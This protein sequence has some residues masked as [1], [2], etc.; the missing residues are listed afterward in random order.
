MTAPSSMWAVCQRSESCKQCYV[1]SCFSNHLN[2]ERSILAVAILGWMRSLY[3]QLVHFTKITSFNT[4][5][6]K[7]A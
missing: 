3:L 5:F 7:N 4:V 6:P 2:T 1:Q